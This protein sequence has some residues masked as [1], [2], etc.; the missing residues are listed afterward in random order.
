[1][2]KYKIFE[3]NTFLKKFRKLD[4]NNQKKLRSKLDNYV[5]PQ[6]RNEPHFGNNIKK[7]TDFNPD[8][9]RY[10]IGDYRVFYGIDDK[11]V[12]VNIVS[13]DNRSYAY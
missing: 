8:T 7:L 4:K 12:F 13:I 9:W 5:Y 1:M 6:L 3:A 11:K 10:R 2:A